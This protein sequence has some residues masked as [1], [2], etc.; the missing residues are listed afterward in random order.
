MTCGTG[1]PLL[2]IPAVALDQAMGATRAEVVMR[3]V[4]RMTGSRFSPRAGV[5]P[6]RTVE[7]KPWTRT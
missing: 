1:I 2:A 3:I 7:Q 4:L 6:G 5:W